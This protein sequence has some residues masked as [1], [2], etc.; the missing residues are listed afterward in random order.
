MGG[1]HMPDWS[2]KFTPAKNPR[3]DL[4]ADFVLDV[5][6]DPPGPFNVF[7]G[8]L[9]S[10]NNT[11]GDEHQ[12]AVYDP[13]LG[14]PQPAPVGG[15]MQPRTSSPAYPVAAAPGSLIRFCC[16]QHAGEVGTLF[17]ATPGQPPGPPLTV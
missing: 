9:V 4:K 11:T 15:V 13:A 7:Q 10:W 5:P 17:V 2:I 14:N 16:T 8:D 12:P 6:G 1:S 3:P